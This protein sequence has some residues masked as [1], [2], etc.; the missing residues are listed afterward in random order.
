MAALKGSKDRF[1]GVTI[2]LNVEAH[3]Q[4]T[5]SA[6]N[7]HLRESL[8]KWRKEGVRG[9]WLRIPTALA[10]LA[11]AAVGSDFDFHHAQP[12]Y[13]MLTA[14]LPNTPSS[15]PSYPHHQFGVGGMV[16]DKE[17]RVLCIQEHSGVT[18]GMKD[19]WKLP[20]GL[21][22]SKE[23]ICDAVQREVLE[24][25]GVRAIFECVA[26]IRETHAGPFGSTDLYAI[27]ILRLDDSYG[28]VVPEP[29]PQESEIAACEWRDLRVFLE[30]KYYAKGLYGSLLKT[31]A[32][33]A[34]RRRRGELGIGVER[35]QMKGL[36]GKPESMYYA[37][38]EALTRARL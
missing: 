12:G 23:D 17:G 7:Q 30:S 36:S 15:L 35:M 31:A 3:G 29:T 27:C 37:G 9:V 20:G 18:A 4:L 21:V 22:D 6:F 2:E 26:S 13:A 25:T 33:V 1:G 10:H 38:G 14:W 28:D 11:G 8:T 24:E 5:A 34:L 16:L 19:F 32:D